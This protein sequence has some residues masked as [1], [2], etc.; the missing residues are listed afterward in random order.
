MA[1]KRYAVVLAA[2]ASV[3][4]SVSIGATV[5]SAAGGTVSGTSSMTAQ[6]PHQESRSDQDKEVCALH[7]HFEEDLIVGSGG[8]IANAVVIIKGAKGDL[9]PSAREVRSK[10]M[11]LCAARTR[12]P[13][14]STVDIVNS[15]GILH[16]IHTYSTRIPP[17]TWRS[18]SSRRKSRRRLLSR[19]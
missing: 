11:R 2:C 12:V 1:M 5:A 3:A 18:P 6:H 7:P 14:G 9:K 17:S 8:G 16:N 4:L 13:A 19:K 10:G 15:D